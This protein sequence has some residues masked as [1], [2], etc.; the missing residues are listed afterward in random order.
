MVFGACVKVI[1]GFYIGC[2]GVVVQEIGG[3]VGQLTLPTTYLV[4]LVCKNRYF[5][6]QFQA[7]Q[8]EVIP[9]EGEK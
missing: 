7:S 3:Y 8:L 1:A 9:C 6:K 4:E 5:D 2:T